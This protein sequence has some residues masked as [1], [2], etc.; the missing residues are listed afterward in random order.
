MPLLSERD[1]R[2]NKKIISEA[3]RTERPK[4]VSQAHL[5]GNIFR[6]DPQELLQKGAH[7]S[8]SHRHFRR[9]KMGVIVD[10]I[11]LTAADAVNGSEKRSRG[12]AERQIAKLEN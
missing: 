11:V 4:P 10:G 8:C 2:L 5:R 9:L 7:P 3:N 12:N 1:D 6:F